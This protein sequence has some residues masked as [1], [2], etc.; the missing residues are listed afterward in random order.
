M[1]I[2]ATSAGY[3]SDNKA[4]IYIDGNL[5]KV[6][7]NENGHHRG[8]HLTVIHPATGK[9]EVAKAFDTYKNSKAMENFIITHP[10]IE[11]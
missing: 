1:V 9:I 7:K 6:A 10:F 4:C 2:Q 8:L 3:D 11:N 5:L